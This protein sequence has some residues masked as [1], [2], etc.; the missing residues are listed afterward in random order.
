LLNFSP[1]FFAI[2]AGTRRPFDVPADRP[3]R[4]GSGARFCYRGAVRAA[5]NKR[6]AMT[7]VG[8]VLAALA[9]PCGLVG[10]PAGSPALAQPLAPA[11][12]PAPAAVPPAA[13][14]PAA[15]RR[16]LAIVVVPAAGAS[17]PPAALVRAAAALDGEG[18]SV[19]GDGV[20]AARAARAAGAVP[21]ARLAAMTRA[22][23]GGAEGWRAYLQ[24]AVP[25]A[26]SRLGKAR[27]D[28]EA[29]LPLPGGLEL[30]ADLSLRLG[31]ALLS[32]GRLD[33]AE[34][35]L[36]LAAALDPQREVSLVEFSPDIVD[37]L[38]RARSRQVP[39]AT[40]V[41]T[42]PGVRGAAIEI[43]G[44]LVGRVGGPSVAAPPAAAPLAPAPAV[45]ALDPAAPRGAA[46]SASLRVSVARGQHV[47]VARR[48]GHEDIAQAVRVPAEG[49]E[50]AL[51]LPEDRVARALSAGLAGMSEDQAS[52]L[53][54]GVVTFADADE[55]LL[56]AATSRRGAPALLAQRCGASLRCSA[57]VEIGY[58]RPGLRAALAAAW[59]ALDRG[60]LR[61]P[62]SLPSDSR[63]LPERTAGGG[64]RC[65]LCR[66]PW[67]WAGVGAAAVVTSAVLLYTL[68]QEPPPPVLV[69]DPGEF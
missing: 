23:E 59:A 16:R 43:D 10:L 52:S 2:S 18:V 31:A 20:A 3:R 5:G 12:A 35:A 7:A 69:V 14:A 6:P 32:L 9:M 46:P 38:G 40:L 67:L 64:T 11:A 28:A 1:A 36:A 39:P 41:I 54:E 15:P 21:A 22:I 24:V 57:V 13:A 37:A 56:L 17:E 4:L 29:L 42:T 49:A 45:A 53:L 60:E 63:V 61:Y 55:I 30:Y 19:I 26:A 33:E 47:V 66:S 50:L 48:R 8:A 62:P 25:F 65:R 68:G 58:V 51:Y 44:Q 27:S 34:D